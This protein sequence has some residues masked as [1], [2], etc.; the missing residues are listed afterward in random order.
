MQGLTQTIQGTYTTDRLTAVLFTVA[1]DMKTTVS[2]AI[3]KYLRNYSDSQLKENVRG[4]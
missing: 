2:V 4:G 1:V 3:Q